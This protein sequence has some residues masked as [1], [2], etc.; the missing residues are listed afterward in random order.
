MH[1]ILRQV[2]I[3][4]TLP[5]CFGTAT[6][7]ADTVSLAWDLSPDSAVIGYKLLYGTSPGGYS[8]TVDVGNRTT[9]TLPGLVDGQ[10]YY[11]AVKAYTFDS[12]ESAASNEVSTIAVGL[13][14]VT[15]DAAVPTPSGTPITWKALSGPAATMEYKFWRFAK[16]AGVWTLGQDYSSSNAYSWTP[17]AADQ[18]TYIVQAWARVQGSTDPYQVVR[19]AGDVTVSNGPIIIGS[20]EADAAMPA[21]AGTKITWRA[22]AI[23]GPAPLQYQFWRYNTGNGTW[24]MARGYSTDNSYA[25]TPGSSEL[26]IYQYQVWVR[27]AGSTALYDQ[28][29]ASETFEIKN[30]PP[31]I[32]S[33]TPDTSS[34]VGSGTPVTWTAQAAGGPGPLQ[35]QFWRFRT[36]TNVWTMVQDYGSSNTFS[37]TPTSADVGSYSLQAWVRRQGSTAQYEAWAAA[38]QIQIANSAPVVTEITSSDGNMVGINMPVT[39]SVKA[40]GGPGPLQLKFWLYDPQKTVWTVLQDYSASNTVTWT[41]RNADM[42][43]YALQVWVKGAST[44][45]PYDSV[46]NA[47]AV[48]VAPALP[49]IVKVGTNNSTAATVGMPIVWRAEITGG[50]GPVEYKFLRLDNVRQVW[51]LVQDYSWDDTFAWVPQPSDEG[52]YTMQVWARRSGSSVA[53][54]SWLSS[55]PLTIV[56]K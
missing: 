18:D 24:T 17:A 7:R 15:S 36:S 49:V 2:V 3:G 55:A 37:W 40:T 54:D 44:T 14:A 51:T 32:A 28:W 5:V 53:Y 50:Q 27:G 19:N 6:A 9:Y 45:G 41:P 43:T 38:P 10:R 13:V 39:W 33:V 23:G 31:A 52:S 30:A 8:T 48:S 56:T 46:A 20:I 21:S 4:L 12:Y 16:S 34:P 47:P 42:G 1:A 26:G 11:F 25:W 35:Y 29:R 22:K